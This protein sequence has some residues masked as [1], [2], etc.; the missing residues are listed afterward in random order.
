MNKPLLLTLGGAALAGL[1]FLGVGHLLDPAPAYTALL[2]PDQSVDVSDSIPVSPFTDIHVELLAADIRVET[3]SGYAMLY[4][5]SDEET[6]VRADVIDDTFYFETQLDTPWH[7]FHP[8]A[9]NNL[10]LTVPADAPLDEITL[11]TKSGTITAS[12]L[13]FGEGEFSTKSGEILLDRLT[14]DELELDAV[15][16]E[17][18]L[19]GSSVGSLS[20]K[21]VS[22]DVTADGSFRDVELE[23]TSG[24]VRLTGSVSA[25]CEAETVSGDMEITASAPSISA[26]TFGSIQWNGTEQ[27][28]QFLLT[29]GAPHFELK[30]VSGDITIDSVL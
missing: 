12:D 18:S 2:S 19:V 17:I 11:S 23:T 3:G 15:S 4:T 9:G 5:L 28:R 8:S 14:C 7:R 10:V 22:G 20:A 30:S 1:V 29:G 6:V 26:K 21:S 13:T 25:A 24:D 16:D 27:G